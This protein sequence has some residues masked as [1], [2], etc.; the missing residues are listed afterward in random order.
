MHVE[1]NG[2]PTWYATYGEGEPLVAF[3]PGLVDARALQPHPQSALADHFRV[4]TPERRGHGHT[5]D[6]AGPYLFEQLADDA[7]AF[8]ETVIGAPAHLVG[9]SDGGIVALLVAQRRPDLARRLA[10]IA[11][12]ARW[13]G[14]I[15]E[16]IDPD[17]EPPDFMR[18]MYGEVSPDGIEHFSTVVGK[19]A[20]MHLVGPSLN[21]AELAQIQS[22]TLIMIADDDEVVLEHAIDVYRSIPQAE[23]AVV[24]GTSHGLVVEKPELCESILIDFLTTDPVVTLAPIR[25][26]AQP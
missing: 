23:L 11:A 8:I 7:A 22:R 19:A 18:E 25:R 13:Q 21:A 26:R 24:P 4:Y 14:W 15:P 6:V 16:A 17:N 1:T 5:P 12:P 3:H 10:V 9:V 2:V 20:E